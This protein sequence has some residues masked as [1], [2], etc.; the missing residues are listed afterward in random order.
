MLSFY[1]QPDLS[2][3]A[4]RTTA[5][6]QALLEK[7]PNDAQIYVVT[8]MPNR[9]SSFVTEVPEFEQSDC[10]TIRRIPLPVHRSGMIDQSRAFVAYAVSAVRHLRG[11]KYDLIYATSSRLMT[12]VFG[13]FVARWKRTR[14]YLDIRDIFVD[15][16]NDVLSKKAIF[17]VKPIILAL[18]RFALK[19]AQK[20]NLV[21]EGFLDYFYRSYPQ[22]SYS[23]Y[24]NGVDPGVHERV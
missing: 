21:S 1:Y 12:A 17:A 20:V 23:F 16:I 7:M 22:L 6:V 24:T 19:R 5:L 18:E 8:T 11:E 9:Y 3:G 13:S 2:A 15:T 10:L 4:F 14:L